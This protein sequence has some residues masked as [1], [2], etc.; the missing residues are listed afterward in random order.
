MSDIRDAALA[1]LQDKYKHTA[2]MKHG[3]VYDNIQLVK[4]SKSMGI[5]IIHKDG[6]FRELVHSI[7]YSS[8]NYNQVHKIWYVY[9]GN[10][11]LSI[12]E[13]EPEDILKLT[14][15]KMLDDEVE[16]AEPVKVTTDDTMLLVTHP[17]D[18][19]DDDVPW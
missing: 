8:I 16:E 9:F 13:Y 15:S 18:N 7:A 11:W 5:T 3:K 19:E 6:R 17:Q 12:N 14:R 1:Y 10:T 4:P 2:K